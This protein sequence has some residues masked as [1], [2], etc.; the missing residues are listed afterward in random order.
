[1][2]E[3]IRR[4]CAS[5][6]MREHYR[7]PSPPPSESW[8]RALPSLLGRFN[9]LWTNRLALYGH[10]RY[11]LEFLEPSPSPYRSLEFTASPRLPSVDAQGNWA[12]VSR[13]ER[14]RATS[15]AR[16]SEMAGGR[17]AL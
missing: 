13:S 6:A 1:M 4:L 12:F 7:A 15:C 3:P 17:L 10:C 2:I 8:R 16:C 5:W 11:S 14:R 9:R